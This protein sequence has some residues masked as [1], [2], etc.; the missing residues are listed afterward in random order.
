M[1]KKKC[2][3]ENY[4]VQ[5]FEEIIDLLYYIYLILQIVFFIMRKLINYSLI[6]LD[7]CLKEFSVRIYIFIYD[8]PRE[9]LDE[10]LIFEKF[11]FLLLTICTIIICLDALQ[12]YLK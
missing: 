11:K 10:D 1:E 3:I 8:L 4:L 7:K 2:S 5:L 6:K 12:E 9:Y